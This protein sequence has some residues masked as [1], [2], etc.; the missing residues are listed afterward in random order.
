MRHLLVYFYVSEE[1]ALNRCK[2]QNGGQDLMAI[3]QFF[4]DCKATVTP[5]P[6]GKPALHT[7]IVFFL[8][9]TS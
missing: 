8:P 6:F 5:F 4:A 2:M 1:V 3:F 7:V 9:I